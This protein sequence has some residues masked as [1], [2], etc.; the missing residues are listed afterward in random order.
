MKFDKIILVGDFDLHIDHPHNPTATEFPNIAMLFNLVQ[1]VTGPTH[2]GG[3]TLSS[4][5]SLQFDFQLSSPELVNWF[6]SVCSSVLDNISMLKVRLSP[7]SNCI[8]YNRKAC[9]K[10]ECGGKIQMSSF[11]AFT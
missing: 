9:R 3:H 1:H 7:V 11:T 8:H 4:L 10:A 5:Y 6:N 2:N